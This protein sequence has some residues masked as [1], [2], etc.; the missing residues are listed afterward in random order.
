MTRNELQIIKLD[1]L[2][3]LIKESNESKNTENIEDLLGVKLF[4]DY[5][6]PKLEEF[7][8]NFIDRYK[9]YLPTEFNQK[10]VREF[11][12]YWFIKSNG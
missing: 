8:Q 6:H 11:L 1:E 9:A 4:S 5:T 3:K 7:I 10:L 12:L 2:N